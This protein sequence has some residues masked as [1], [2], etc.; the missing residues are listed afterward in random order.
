[1]RLRQVL[2]SAALAV[3]CVAARDSAHPDSEAAAAATIDGG[4][5]Y[6]ARSVRAVGERIS[7]IVQLN[8]AP[9]LVT[10]R[11]DEAT[12]AAEALAKAQQLL[13]SATAA[14]RGR[15]WRDLGFGS[16]TEPQDLV[17]AIERDVAGM[18]FDATR[19]RLLVDPQRLLPDSGHGDPDV[20][21]D[22]SILLTTGVAPDEP[23]AG[24]Y[25]AHALL[26]G[27][28]LE[29]PVT[30]DALLARSALAEGS[31]NLAAFTLLFGG[32]GLESE[33][34]SGALHPE[35]V[36][37]G[38][39]VPETMRTASPV[40]AALLEFVYLDGFAQVASIAR[41]GG[42]S[43]VRQERR[44]RRTTRDVLHLDRPTAPPVA[45]VE[46]S[47]PA[48][49]GLSPVDRDSL[50]EQGIVAL[51][52]LL[53][54]KDNLGMIAGDGWVADVLWRFEPGPGSTTK[55]GEGAT[56]WLT[57]WRRDE[58]AAD[59]SYGLERCL[60]ARFPGESLEGDRERGTQTLRR[61][62]RVYRIERS[63][64][65]VAFRVATP[66]IEAKTN[67]TP[68]KKGPASQPVPSKN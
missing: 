15:A 53:T 35:D 50:G 18:T 59:F 24:H 16:G 4:D 62:D 30:T 52:S 38:R 43:R 14:A 65:Q 2:A 12:R 55:T 60:Q 34:V 57:Q 5:A 48:S 44:I 11:A 45:I 56:I 66:A 42:F 27:P 64:T 32:V 40:V 10:V 47:L 8:R 22:A 58:D 20:D 36:L 63:G 6:L 67:P 68:K 31:A 51:V 29:G 1:M 61:A 49:L 7:A 23:I 13:T 39:L 25:M 17:V 3:S 21:P 26:D 19:E 28:S 33:V 41:T 46:P 9:S 54:G 37:G